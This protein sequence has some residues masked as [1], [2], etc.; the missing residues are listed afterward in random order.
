MKSIPCVTS[1]SFNPFWGISIYNKYKI[2]TNII[3]HWNT[4]RIF[5]IRHCDSLWSVSCQLLLKATA[6]LC[7]WK[8]LPPSVIK[9]AA[10]AKVGLSAIVDRD[11]VL[12][13]QS[14]TIMTTTQSAHHWEHTKFLFCYRLRLFMTTGWCKDHVSNLRSSCLAANTGSGFCRI[15]KQSHK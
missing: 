1:H 13:L 11:W 9:G 15:N 2:D 10:V 7:I 3:S 5:F 6:S 4:K 8:L 14:C 12:D